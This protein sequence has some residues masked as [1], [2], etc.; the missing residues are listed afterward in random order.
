M[1]TV[2][3]TTAVRRGEPRECTRRTTL[4]RPSNYSLLPFHLPASGNA[5]R[6]CVL[7]VASVSQTAPNARRRYDQIVEVARLFSWRTSVPI[8]LQENRVDAEC[9]IH[10]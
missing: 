5:E 4:C 10:A 9:R 3:E 6:S 7:T 1:P 2:S 8:V